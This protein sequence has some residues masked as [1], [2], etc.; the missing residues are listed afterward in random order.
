MIPLICKDRVIGKRII[1]INEDKKQPT[2]IF[3]KFKFLENY[4]KCYHGTKL[5]IAKLINKIF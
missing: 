3:E 1:R 4:E 2:T 5:N